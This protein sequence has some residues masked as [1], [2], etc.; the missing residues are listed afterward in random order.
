MLY[1]KFC[2]NEAT[3]WGLSQEKATA[4]QYIQWKAQHGSP[5]ISVNTECGLV[6]ATDHPWLAA[7]P[8][9]LV[10]DP[11][12]LPSQGLVEFKNP[13][14]CRDEF[15]TNAVLSKK[16]TCLSCNSTNRKL[17]LK[18][19]DAYYNQVQM[20]MFCTNTQWCDFVVR[21]QVDL[22]VE[23]ITLNESFCRSVLPKLRILFFN[24]VLPELPLPH[25]PIREPTWIN[26]EEQWNNR[27]SALCNI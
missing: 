7:T 1:S 11:Q 10:N 9:G 8:D 15:I 5:G 17:S 27:I 20:A 18:N 14:S 23:R 6:I 25:R 21:T 26:N 3:R 24:S 16:L 2:G 22:H 13:H 12:T 19:T 4:E